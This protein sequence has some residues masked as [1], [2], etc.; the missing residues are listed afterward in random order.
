MSNRPKA[1]AEKDQH[2]TWV[3]Q[4]EKI[5]QTSPYYAQAEKQYI[6]PN[7][8]PKTAFT[9][10]HKPFCIGLAL[11]KDM[12]AIL[13]REYRPGPEEI[14]LDLPCGS[15]NDG[16]DPMVAMGR[17]LEEETGWSGTPE[18]VNVTWTGPYSDQK[19]YTFLIRDCVKVGPQKLDHDEFIE[20]VTMPLPE[21]V[22]QWVLNGR[23][24]NTAAA[25]YALHHMQKVSF[26]W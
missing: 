20:V 7:G 6:L 26:I 13:V 9:G 14:L 11:T 21:F 23:T 18:L 15:I 2:I 1:G 8:K 25:I 10:R 3:K 12:E 19:R 5:I 4:G 17:E 24:T 22:H 16:E